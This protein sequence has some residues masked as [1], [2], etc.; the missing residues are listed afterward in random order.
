MAEKKDGSKKT[1]TKKVDEKAQVQKAVKKQLKKGAKKTL[2]NRSVQIALIVIVVAIIVALVV[3]YLVKPEIFSEIF[4]GKSNTSGENGS[5]NNNQELPYGEGDLLFHTI[6]IGQGDCLLINFPDGK[7][8][9]IDCGSDAEGS[10][11]MANS[12]ISKYVTDGQL[13]YVMLTH[14]DK[15][16]VGYLNEVIEDYQCDH[17]IMPNIK[18]EPTDANKSAA[19]NALDST[20]LA[21]FTDPDTVSTIVY[22]EFFIAALSEPNCEIMLT[23]GNFT[24]KGENWKM[25]IF[26]WSQEMWD[27]RK[28]NTAYLLNGLSPVC[29]LQYNGKRIVLTGDSNEQSYS[30]PDRVASMKAFY[31]VDTLDCDVLKVAHHGSDTSSCDEFLDFVTC[32]TA[33]IS[34]GPTTKHGHPRYE[35]LDRLVERDYTLYRTDLH[36]DVVVKISGN[37]LTITPQNENIDNTT[38]WTGFT[39]GSGTESKLAVKGD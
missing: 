34:C 23:V 28:V 13:D 36:G 30:E 11:E 14:S 37:T 20:K 3:V 33:I 26:C 7:D 17:I 29:I 10:Y 16:H 15:D 18:A 2:K 25:D 39:N 32:E 35:A 38:L 22:A 31:G 1:T 6:N 5:S 8:M 21:M 19:V 24:I 9:L 4:G 12:Y 27:A